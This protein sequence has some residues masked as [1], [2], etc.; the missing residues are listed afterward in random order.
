MEGGAR[1]ALP[2]ASIGQ[3][4]ARGGASVLVMGGGG[5]QLFRFD[6]ADGG[7]DKVVEFYVL[8][9]KGARAHGIVVKAASADSEEAE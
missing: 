8:D 6:L 5:A 4:V 1:P 3:G 9:E 2:L 7:G